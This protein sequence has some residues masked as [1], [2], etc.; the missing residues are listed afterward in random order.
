MIA[1]R[2][3][4]K[5]YGAH[6]VLDDVSL[7]IPKGKITALIGCNGSGKSTLLA[8]IS[9]LIQKDKGTVFI[10]DKSLEAYK[11]SLLAKQLSVL[12]QS[13]RLS[14]KL[15]VRELVSF[16]RFPHSQGRLT[17][18]D[19]QK[20]DEALR[21]LDLE[22]I[23]YSYVDELSGGQQ[24]RVYMAMV[25]AQD[26][27]YI[28]LD[29]PLN[30]LDMKHAVQIMRTLQKLSRELH[31]TIVIVIHEINFAAQYADYTAALKDTKMIHSGPTDEVLNAAVLKEVFDM[32]IA[33]ATV[34]GKKFCN[35]F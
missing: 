15:T 29:E 16:G 25:V 5:S 10:N 2:N 9:R 26:T 30:N 32:D 14:L 34:D 19:N 33:I 11:S 12:K 20:I 4:S 13:N 17:E 24:Q 8:I 35:Y 28:L 23:Q 31:K 7:D 27:E 18:I 22:A 6:V 1:V 3:I 21:Y